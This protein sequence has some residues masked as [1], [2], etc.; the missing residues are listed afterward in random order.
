VLGDVGSVGKHRHDLFPGELVISLDVL[1]VVPPAANLPS[2]AATSILVPVMHG[3]PNRIA[4][5]IVI[6]G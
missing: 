3:F 6:P 2:T 4:G 5:S 1:D